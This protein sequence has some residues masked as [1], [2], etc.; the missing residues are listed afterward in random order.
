MLNPLMP[1]RAAS[2]CP[3]GK[4]YSVGW[5]KRILPTTSE[6]SINSPKLAGAINGDK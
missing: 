5:L 1:N 3:P 4:T 2:P 6:L